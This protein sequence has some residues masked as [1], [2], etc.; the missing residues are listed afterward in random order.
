MS[1]ESAEKF[2]SDVLYHSELREQFN[3]VQNP[4]EFLNVARQL[5][6]DFSTA[7]LEAVA[8]AHS[9]GVHTRRQTGIWPWL[10]SVNWIDRNHSNE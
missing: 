5:G 4:E 8:H 9:L 7:E 2:L 6:Y 3:D 10:R 1:K